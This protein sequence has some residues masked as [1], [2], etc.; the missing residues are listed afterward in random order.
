MFFDR[1][2]SNFLSFLERNIV[3][4]Y[5]FAYAFGRRHSMRFV[6]L[7]YLLASCPLQAPT[8]DSFPSS[9]VI[10]LPPVPN[11]YLIIASIIINGIKF[12]IHLVKL[13]I[14]ILCH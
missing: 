14:Y 13:L 6:S 11:K 5:G 2:I 1:R 10:L 4:Y 12:I 7:S 9:R 3:F 8:W